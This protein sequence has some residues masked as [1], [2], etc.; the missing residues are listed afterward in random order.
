MQIAERILK[1]THDNRAED[2]AVRLH[3]PQKAGNVW[4]CRY[5]IN[6]P[7]RPKTMSVQGV[8]SVQATLL[9]MQM[10][11]TD[12][13]TSNYHKAG[14]LIFERPGGGFGFPVPNGLRDLLEGDDAKFL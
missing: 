6:W 2:V 12:L 10:I 1:L 5:E 3:A 9:A 4:V 14:E 11:G 13:Y 7:E 8:D